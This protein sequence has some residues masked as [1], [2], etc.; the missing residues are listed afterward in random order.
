MNS[1]EEFENERISLNNESTLDIWNNLPDDLPSLDDEL[2]KGYSRQRQ[3]ITM[4]KAKGFVASYLLFKKTFLKDK[5]RSKGARLWHNSMNIDPS[6]IDVDLFQICQSLS[7]LTNAF[8]FKAEQYDPNVNKQELFKATRL[9]WYMFAFQL[10]FN[11]PIELT[12]SMFGYTMLY[13]YTDDFIDSNRIS[14]EAKQHFAKVF[15]QRLLFGDEPSDLGSLQPFAEQIKKIFDMVQLI[16]NDWIRN[17]INQPIYMS[18][19]VI[20]QCQMKSTQQHAKSNEDCQ[21]TFE[22]IEEISARKGGASV[23]AA[24]FM[25]QGHLTSTQFAYLEYIGFGL[26]LLD[27]LQDVK[28][29]LQNNHRTIFTYSIVHQQTL[30]KP[31]SRLIR[32]F[33]D[34]SIFKKFFNNENA[35]LSEYIHDS[36]MMFSILLIIEAASH[37]KQF[38]SKQ[39]Y[40]QLSRRSPI[41]FKR[42]KQTRLEKRLFFLLRKQLF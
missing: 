30:D 21:L 41:K 1:F 16:E 7:Q 31:T 24:G 26:Q 35:Q 39:F 33:L 19:A 12:D 11:L 5:F 8:L 38:Y 40:R 3:R 4:T 13:P 42:R 23:V 9:I 10:Q 6:T 34:K 14:K 36:M 15:F 2:L 37:L 28:E 22:E 18:L 17:E 29:D 20:H 25:I 27:D 32:Y